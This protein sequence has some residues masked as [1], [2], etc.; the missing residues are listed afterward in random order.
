MPIITSI[1][2]YFVVWWFM[3]FTVLPWGVKGQYEDGGVVKGTEPGAPSKPVMKKKMIQNSVLS[4]VVWAI[5]MVIIK[6]DLITID[7]IP[8]F[9]DFV[10]KDI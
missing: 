6:F 4:L 9:P 7:N 5:I 10:P 8:F 3:L 2:I 1:A